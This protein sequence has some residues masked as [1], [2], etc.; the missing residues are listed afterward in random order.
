MTKLVL[1]VLPAAAALPAQPAL[2]QQPPPPPA[3]SAADS[4]LKALYD[5]YA[6][7]SAKEFGY[8]ENARGETEQAGFL[9]RVDAASELRRAAHLQGLLARLNAIPVAQLSPGERTNAA[10]LRA[11]LEGAVA[12]AR[13]REWEMPANS[14]SNFWTYL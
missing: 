7:W 2:A 9:P 5:G 8:F 4:E 11:I 6:E 10:V 3:A 1:A 14:D 12:D 13:F